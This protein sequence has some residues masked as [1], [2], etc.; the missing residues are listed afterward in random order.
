MQR[1]LDFTI[2]WAKKVYSKQLIAIFPFHNSNS[3]GTFMFVVLA[4]MLHDI[5]QANL[6]LI[7]R[8]KIK[9]CR[10]QNYGIYGIFS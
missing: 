7:Y 5:Q 8:S 6:Y 3:L 2:S 9:Q 1:K 4:H 10:F